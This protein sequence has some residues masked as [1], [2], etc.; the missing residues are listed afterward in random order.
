[1]IDWKGDFRLKKKFFTGVLATAVIGSL[2]VQPALTDAAPSKKVNLADEMVSSL[3]H[4][5]IHKLE[6]YK[7]KKTGSFSQKT[8][9]AMTAVTQVT[10]ANTLKPS[11]F[12]SY[13]MQ[14]TKG[15]TLNVTE[16]ASYNYGYVVVNEETGNEYFSGDTL[17]AGTY[18][19]VVFSMSI[20]PVTYSLS[21]SGVTM[22]MDTQLPT[23]S[24][25]SPKTI[26]HRLPKNTTALTLSGSATNA[27][28]TFYAL[29]GS[30]DISFNSTSFNKQITVSTGYHGVDLGATTASGNM[31]VQS[32]TV[33]APGLKRIA[34]ADLY[35]VSANVSKEAFPY[36]ADTIVLARGDLYTDALAG[37]PLAALNF[38]PM[39][40]T[41]T[42]ALPAPIT[43]EIKRLQ[44]SRAIILGGTGSVSTAVENSL[45]N[46]GMTVERIA[47]ADRFVVSANIASRMKAD[48][49]ETDTAIIASGLNYPDALSASS[50]AGQIPLPIL[51]VSTNSVP[52]SIETYIKAN[53]IKNFIIVGGPSTVSDTVKNKLKSFGGVV[54]RI[55][56]A[57]RF[58]VGVNI[59]NYFYDEQYGLMD[60]SKIVFATGLDF[61]DA[62]SGSPM[63]ASIYSPM[64]LTYRDKLDPMVKSYLEKT[65]PSITKRDV[66]YLIGNTTTVNTT[67]ESYLK[68]LID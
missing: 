58:E 12:H 11:N 48:G 53:G 42:N 32:H 45:R 43:A 29:D 6:T 20:A 13:K 64:L 3:R 63:A 68:S 33:T 40:L 15:G 47:G 57:N 61:P 21:V 44:P 22:E 66:F 54:D 34:G 55:S 24:V 30:D 10:V 23:L 27:S 39:L 17:P 38:A 49:F 37:G 26:D 9:R 65:V 62:I 16:P 50:P 31:V 36:G 59:A 52:A 18:H 5:T 46:M 56:G 19:F 41:T 51:E 67:V 28:N 7:Q 1:M 4:K 2:L 25:T 14:V 35:A 60:P 8:V